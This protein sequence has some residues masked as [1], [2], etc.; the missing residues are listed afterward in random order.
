MTGQRFSY[1]TTISVEPIYISDD[2]GYANDGIPVGDVVAQVLPG[3]D[4]V[5]LET[6]EL[7]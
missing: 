4:A 3:E 6:E 7:E 1:E 2:H 5:E